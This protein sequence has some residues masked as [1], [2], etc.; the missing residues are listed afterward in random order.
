MTGSD[1][2]QLVCGWYV[3]RKYLWDVPRSCQCVSGRSSMTEIK[4]QRIHR[5]IPTVDPM[6][7][8]DYT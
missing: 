8:G 1:W 7:D 4:P 5:V 3:Y 2:T 6:E